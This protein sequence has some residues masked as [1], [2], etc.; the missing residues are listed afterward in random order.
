MKFISTTIKRKWLDKILSGEK[1][2]ERKVY[3]KFWT[4][5]LEPLTK[6]D[7]KIGINL[8][9]GRKSYKFKVTK[10]EFNAT[11][12]PTEIDGVWTL[13]WYDIHI[14]ERIK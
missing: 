1:T 8:L 10:V 5:R 12:D 7:E 14:G 2:I 13:L 3:T 9:C 6:T 4:K 11:E